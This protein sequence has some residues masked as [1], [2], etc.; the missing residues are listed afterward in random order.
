MFLPPNFALWLQ[1]CSEEMKGFLSCYFYC[2]ASGLIN[3]LKTSFLLLVLRKGPDR[4]PD[5]FWCL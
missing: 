2:P 5:G 3:F 4:G 1:H